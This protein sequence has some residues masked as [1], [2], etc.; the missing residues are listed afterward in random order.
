MGEKL[1]ISN[2]DGD[3]E[4]WDNLRL[5]GSSCSRFYLGKLYLRGDKMSAL[6]TFNR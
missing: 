5:P 2:G 3:G 1:V 6:G 4:K